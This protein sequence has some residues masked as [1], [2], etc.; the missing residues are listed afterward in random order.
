MVIDQLD[1]ITTEVVTHWFWAARDLPWTVGDQT[2]C[3]TTA[4]AVVP[5]SG[6]IGRIDDMDIRGINGRAYMMLDPADID[7]IGGA[8]WLANLD[9]PPGQIWLDDRICADDRPYIL[10]HE[11]AELWAMLV[12]G[13]AYQY[14]H[15][16]YGLKW[17][18]YV[19][20]T[21]PEV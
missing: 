13:C 5:G 10:V 4:G 8:H 1:S 16:H 20:Q 6:L 17:E 19:S 12:C 15:R 18:L 11:L 9:I 21:F 7:Y 3:I 14:A 2:G